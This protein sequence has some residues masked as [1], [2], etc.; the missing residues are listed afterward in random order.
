LAAIADYAAV[1]ASG[2]FNL[3]GVYEQLSTPEF[4]FTHSLSL[5]LGLDSG[6][7]EVG[8]HKVILIR[9]VSEDGNILAQGEIRLTVPSARVPG[10]KL[11]QNFAL[12]FRDVVFPGPGDYQ[13]SI[14]I[15]DEERRTLPFTIERAPMPEAPPPPDFI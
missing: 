10:R 13:V 5:A 11:H 12:Q 8:T 3:I 14:L 4:P 2:K 6:P 1:D 15:N 9:I 7:A